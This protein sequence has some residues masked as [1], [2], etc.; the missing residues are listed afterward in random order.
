MRVRPAL[1]R[2]F[3]VP[4]NI[5]CQKLHIHYVNMYDFGNDIKKIETSYSAH[6][7]TIQGLSLDDYPLVHEHFMYHK[8]PSLSSKKCRPFW[9]TNYFYYSVDGVFICGRKTILFAR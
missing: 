4:E 7:I 5:R 9:D 8:L 1:D 2:F 3:S 6:P